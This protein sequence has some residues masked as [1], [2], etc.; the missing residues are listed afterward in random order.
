MNTNGMGWGYNSSTGGCRGGPGSGGG[1]GGQQLS[2][3][4]TVW[5]VTTTSQSGPMGTFAGH[6]NHPGN[7]YCTNQSNVQSYPGTGPQVPGGQMV[8]KSSFNGPSQNGMSAVAGAR[9]HIPYSGGAG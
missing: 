4:A 1:G 9:H 6:G 7:N 2:V 5:G 3:V 8:M